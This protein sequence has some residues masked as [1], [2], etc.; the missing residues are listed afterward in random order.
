MG[1]SELS[2]V[3]GARN[4]DR[5]S[6]ASVSAHLAVVESSTS[7]PD[8]SVSLLCPVQKMSRVAEKAKK[9]H[10][11]V[12]C[13][14]CAERLDRTSFSKEMLDPDNPA[15]EHPRCKN[16]VTGGYSVVGGPTL[17]QPML[18]SIAG[19][20]HPSASSLTRRSLGTKLHRMEFPLREKQFRGRERVSA[21]YR[22]LA[23]SRY[24]MK[25]L[26]GLAPRLEGQCFMPAITWAAGTV[27]V[28]A[29]WFRSCVTH[30]SPK[31]LMT[32]IFPRGYFLE[33]VT[34][35]SAAGLFRSGTTGMYIV[36]CTLNN[37]HRHYIGYDGWR[38]V[39]Y[40]PLS[41]ELVVLDSKDLEDAKTGIH[42]IAQL[43]KKL[44]VKDFRGVFQLWKKTVA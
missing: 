32:H 2:I 17:S 21:T 4:E 31:V 11:W 15:S 35:T 16:C 37:G 33:R 9:P 19:L 40:E 14:Q 20:A 18:D 1:C 12:V 23:H 34:K 3:R 27:K 24:L 43:R 26:T 22:Q 44:H 38:G 10:H 28:T 29:A 6:C 36:L 30:V 41:N 25:N 8:S 42:P 7:D 5:C 13:Y 39:I